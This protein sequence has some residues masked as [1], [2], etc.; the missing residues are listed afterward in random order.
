MILHGIE[1]IRSLV[2]SIEIAADHRPPLLFLV[3]RI[4]YPPNK[5]DKIR[6]FHWLSALSQR[7]R[8]F[9]ASFVD[10]DADWQYVDVV[11][12]YCQE[13]CIV[14]LSRQR[15]LW[16]AGLTFLTDQ[17]I[18]TLSYRHEKIATWVSQMVELHQIEDVLVFSSSMA[19]YVDSERYEQLNRVIDFVD[20]DSDKWQQYAKFKPWP[21]SWVYNREAQRLF[22]YERHI[23]AAFRKAFFVSRE[24]ARLFI[25][26]TSGEHH[27][28]EH[29][30]NGVGMHS[31]DHADVGNPF[32][33]DG[34][35]RNIVFVG[36]LDYWPNEDAVRWFVNKVY[37]VIVKHDASIRFYVVGSNP[38]PQVQALERISGVRVVA[39]VADVKPYLLYADVAVA[40]LR[41]ARGV[42][43]KVLEALAAG[44]PCIASQK[45]MEG[46]DIE[47][48]NL[49][50]ASDEQSWCQLLQKILHQPRAIPNSAAYICRGLEQYNW[51]T[52]AI[53]V[54]EIIEREGEA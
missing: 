9:L 21:L 34:D 48:D 6:S 45:A 37:S 30:N 8:V 5:G 32:E 42:Q 43:N 36:T 23:S 18:T 51:Q 46:I 16:R 13:V 41:V 47:C 4:P 26:K 10:H 19:Q 15:R 1:W 22:N 31:I 53:R 49:Y 27:W 44:A 50:E 54:L 25:E 40:P 24:E 11:K 52:N 3:H 28:I 29:V 2:S 35:G 20:V 38:T 39:N 17:P 14:G 12:R 33:S 7:Y